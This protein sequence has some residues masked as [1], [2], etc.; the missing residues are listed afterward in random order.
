LNRLV[1]GKSVLVHPHPTYDRFPRA[2]EPQ[3][4]RGRLEL[5]FFGFI[6]PY[7]GL[8]TLVNALA[9]LAD[10]EVYLTVVGEPWYSTRELEANIRASGAP[11]VELHLEYVDDATAAAF[12]ARADLLVLPYRA[13]T[14]SGVAALAYH[15]DRPVLATRV[16]GLRDVVEEGRTGFLVDPDS[17]AQLV[18]RLRSVT[19]EQL[20]QM[21]RYI[22]S[23]KLRFTWGSLAG[24]LIDLANEIGTGAAHRRAAAVQEACE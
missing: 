18:D 7:K 2:A 12:F 3:T 13:A 21:R 16:G 24:A 17:P 9:K 22:S 11:N 5:L 10:P 8:D 6:R 4:S 15:Y 23:D 20:E 19:R 1:P 14:G